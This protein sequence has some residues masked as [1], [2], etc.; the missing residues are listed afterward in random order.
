M[1]GATD[2]RL[3]YLPVSPWSERARWALDHHRL[4]Y[5]TIVHVPFLGE[6][7]LRRFVGQEKKHATVPVLLA[8]D[9]VLSDSWDI[10]HYADEHGTGAKLVPPDRKP[11]IRKW[12]ELADETMQSAR[13]LVLAAMLASPGALDESLPPNM[14]ELLHPLFRPAARFVTRWFGRKYALST[15]DVEARV[16]KLRA[17]FRVLRASLANMQYLLGTFSYADIAMATCL[18]AVVPVSNPSI[19]LGPATREVWTQPALAAEFAEL[20]TW[21]DRLYEQHRPARVRSA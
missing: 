17:T 19:R 1:A 10:A 16:E 18:Q 9:R 13:A 7:K 2:L 5:R 6:R 15:H 4:V 14:P 21:R 20:I 12:N 11:E 8:G 3:I